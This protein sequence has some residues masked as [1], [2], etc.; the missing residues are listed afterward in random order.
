MTKL[1]EKDKPLDMWNHIYIVVIFLIQKLWFTKNFF[2]ETM[3]FKTKVYKFRIEAKVFKNNSKICR[4]NKIWTKLL[5]VTVY[6]M[7]YVALPD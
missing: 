3:I 4:R 1:N 7:S 2:K 5:Y 6:L